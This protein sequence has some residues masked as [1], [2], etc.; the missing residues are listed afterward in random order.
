VIL[1]QEVEES[2]AVEPML[3]HERVG[4]QAV[5]CRETIRPTCWLAGRT[6]A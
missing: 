6:V 3:G 2:A 5:V 4:D 1:G